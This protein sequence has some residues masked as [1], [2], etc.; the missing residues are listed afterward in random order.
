MKSL[1]PRVLPFLKAHGGKSYLASRII[2]LMPPNDI[3]VEPFVYGG[4]VLINKPSSYEQYAGDINPRVIDAWHAVQKRPVWLIEALREFPYSQ[5]TFDL[6]KNADIA[7]NPSDTL[8]DRTVPFIIR[9][10]MSR[11]GFGKDYGWSDRLRGKKRP[12]GPIPGDVNA[13]ETMLD[14]SIPITEKRIRYTEFFNEKALD[15]IEMYDCKETLYYLDPPYYPDSRT[16][17]NAYE[18]E[19]SQDDH[20]ELLDLARQLNGTVMISGYHCDLYDRQLS[21]WKLHE[22]HMPNHSGQ[23]EKKQRRIECL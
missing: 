15:W 22:F 14:V 9:N 17:K 16:A 6:A 8:I 5:E 11:G 13:W 19:M 21:N 2:E 20:I 10:R 1:K 7:R 12:G 23:G 18:F 4:S 3:Y